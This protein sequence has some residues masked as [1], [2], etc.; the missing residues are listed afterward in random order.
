MV[1]QIFPA[2][3]TAVLV[4]GAVGGLA[5]LQLV[6]KPAAIR[7][8]AESLPPQVATVDVAAVQAQSW[9]DRH[10]FTGT[11][12]ADRDITLAPMLSG[13]VTKVGFPNG[14]AV[15]SGDLLF[16]FDTSV[17]IAERAAVAAALT[18]AQATLDRESKLDTAGFAAQAVLGK[19]R[20]DRDTAAANLRRIDAAIAQKLLRAGFDGRLDIAAVQMGDYVQAGSTLTRLHD[21]SRVN[22]TF[23]VPEG[24][25]EGIAIGSPVAAKV[26]SNPEF[27]T[28][29]RNR[30]AR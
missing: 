4:A 27:R 1:K 11:I 25:V 21:G 24:A 26:A 7:A 17:E 2:A 29:R 9:R 14:G 10:T 20:S 18:E 5:Y 23:A 3:A 30:R 6:Y 15:K 22:V 28:Y 12:E 8:Y 13:I 16:E 19:A